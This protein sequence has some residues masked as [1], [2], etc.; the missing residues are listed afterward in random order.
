VG[1]HERTPVQESLAQM[2]DLM[3]DIWSQ[4]VNMNQELMGRVFESFVNR[5]KI[6]SCK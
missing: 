4:T 3:H 5:S 6:M 2:Q 1:M